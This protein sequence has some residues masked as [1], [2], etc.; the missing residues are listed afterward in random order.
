MIKGE[1]ESAACIRLDALR[2]VDCALELEHAVEYLS[3]ALAE[4]GDDSLHQRIELIDSTLQELQLRL[5]V[6]RTDVDSD[7]LLV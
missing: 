4:Y 2:V 7:V 5:H 3:L 1:V 6:L